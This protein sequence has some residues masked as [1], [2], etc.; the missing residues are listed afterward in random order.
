M[1][2]ITETIGY[3]VTTSQVKFYLCA[4][5]YHE[6]VSSEGRPPNTDRFYRNSVVFS[7]LLFLPIVGF[8]YRACLYFPNK[9]ENQKET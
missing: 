8:M 3:P 7:D 2:G 9:G 6:C 5:A 4:V 1:A